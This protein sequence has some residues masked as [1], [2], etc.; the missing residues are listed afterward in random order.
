MSTTKSSSIIAIVN[1]KGGVGKTTTAV[2][3]AIALTAIGKRV[4]AVDMD[5]QANLLLHLFFRN[6]VNE[7][8]ESQQG[9]SPTLVSHSSGVDILPLSFWDADERQFAATIRKVASRYDVV[10]IDSPP[11]LGIRLQTAVSVADVILIPTE[12]E[13]LAIDGLVKLLHLTEEY[14]KP[15]LGIV[16][17]R[18]NVKKSA[19][20]FFRPQVAEYFPELYIHT[21]IPDSSLF[22]SAAA[23]RTHGFDY[24]KKKQTNP[25]LEAY[26]ELANEIL[27][28]LQ[29][30]QYA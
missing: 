17:T 15:V 8:K 11:S 28:R 21:V 24:W 13:I 29:K 25:G 30:E 26:K 16:L 23:E 22:P 18:Y 5:E 10:L 14:Q 27:H 9:G 19:H 2:H 7:I 3:L 12:P 20:K 4:L 1:N 6:R